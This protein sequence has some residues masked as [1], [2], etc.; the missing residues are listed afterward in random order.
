MTLLEQIIA[1]KQSEI[2][3][4]KSAR[5]EMEA[6]PPSPSRGFAAALRRPGLSIIAEIKRRSPSKGVLRETLDPAHL[7]RSYAAGGAA[8]IS[9][10][11][12]RTFFGAS[13][14]DFSAA[15]GTAA[16]PLLRKDFMIDAA[17]LH[18]AR[19]MNAD[20]VLLIVRILDQPLLIEMLKV[21]RSLGMDALVE[22]HDEPELQRALAAGAEVI[23]VN[24]RDLATFDVDPGLA[25]RLRP[26]IP[27]GRIAVAESGVRTRDDMLRISDAG[28]DA[29]LIGETL[30]R[31]PDPAAVLRTLRGVEP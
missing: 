27:A 5:P 2:A 8:A 20:A 30:V 16:L 17:Q 29:V 4:L 11:T 6:A 10:L 7:A 31:A 14:D 12:D 1:E 18:Q 21:S 23:G 22:V 26:L 28:F 25:L 3:A 9:C 13:P 19:Q 15:R 24:A